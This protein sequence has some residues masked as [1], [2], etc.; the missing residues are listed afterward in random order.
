MGVDSATGTA[1]YPLTRREGLD[2]E[3]VEVDG[4]LLLHDVIVS[5]ASL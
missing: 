4:D 1:A 2:T 5:F 3:I